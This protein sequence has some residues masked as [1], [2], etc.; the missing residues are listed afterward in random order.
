MRIYII[1]APNHVASCYRNTTTISYQHII[2]DMYRWVY[3]SDDGMKKLF[4]L[5][6]SAAHN[7]NLP[8]PVQP[9]FM[10]NDYHRAQLQPGVNFDDLLHNRT[11]PGIERTLQFDASLDHPAVLARSKDGVTISLLAL[12]NE[13]FVRGTSEAFLGKAI[14]MVNPNL[15]NAFRRWERTNWKYMFQMPTFMSRDMIAA[16]EEIIDTFVDYFRLP[17]AERSDCNQ[18]VRASEKLARD[19]GLCELDRAKLFMLHFWA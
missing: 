10:F 18:F 14:F 11:I 5:D 8:K 3:F 9:A 6:P 16:K 1:T 13:L 12:C 2:E 17:Y 19:I 7:A 4:A 15:L